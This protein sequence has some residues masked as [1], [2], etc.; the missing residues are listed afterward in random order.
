MKTLVEE[1]S[2]REVV[3]SDD[4]PLETNAPGPAATDPKW[5]ERW[6]SQASRVAII[7]GVVLAVCY[8]A[9]IVVLPIVVAWVISLVLKPPVQWLGR[10]R[11]P[12]AIA[13]LIVLIVFGG[14]AGFAIVTLGKP[15]AVW[16]QSAPENLPK[17]KEKFQAI[18]RPAAHL[19]AVAS[20]MG[21]L[22]EPT[23]T[24]EPTSVTIADN[25]LA[26]SLFNWTWTFLAGVGETIALIFLL[27][28][29]GDRFLQ[30]LV[31]VLPTMHNK[32]QAVEI[33]REI[34]HSVSRYLFSV[35]VINVCVGFIVGG[36]LHFAG[37]PGAAMWGGVA[38]V[39]N[40][41][42]YLG[43]IV[44]VSAVA[45]TGLLAFDS[46]GQGLVPGAIYLAIHL[47][48]ANL[49]TPFILGRRF[50]LNPVIIFITLMFFVW[51]WGV[52]GAL[53]AVPLLVTA[54][55]LCER[56]P[57]LSPWGELL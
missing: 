30:N 2:G 48:E 3:V 33:S 21:N 49:I 1:I 9:R 12:S 16:I 38:A 24:K 36:A 20:S 47:T 56:I 10:L 34:Q 45:V 35:T 52:L 6:I 18:M 11:I 22:G 41:I 44:G 7:F 37:M 26:N 19:S 53:L 4:E 23:K 57:P 54:K 50:T 28:A 51:L 27:L 43:P 17:L 42:P 31:H 46:I 40:Y 39:V 25:H 5:T 8:F 15:A 13:A 29:T 32:K 14:A 55:V